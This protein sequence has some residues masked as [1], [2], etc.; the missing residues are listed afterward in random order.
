MTAAPLTRAGMGDLPLLLELIREFYAVDHHGYDE[1]R[2]RA[3]LPPLLEGDEHGVIW[4]IGKP[5]QGYAVIAWGYS[6]ESGGRDALIDEIYL[7]S[8]NAGLGTAAL[9]AIIDD[10]RAR[11]LRRMFLETESHNA[12]VRRF[13]ARA[14]FEQDDSVWMSRSLE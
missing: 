13:Y 11:G 14:G 9:R 10:C 3:C 12:Q 1:A 2:L 5:A 4:M 7:R 6:L 8:R